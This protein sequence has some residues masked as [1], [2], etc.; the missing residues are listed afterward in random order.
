MVWYFQLFKSFPQFIMI[1][2]VKV[3]GTV[4][5]TQANFSGIP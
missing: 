1:H 2:T 4:D 3:F 5:E